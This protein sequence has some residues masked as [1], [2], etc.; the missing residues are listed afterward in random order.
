MDSLWDKTTKTLRFRP[1][2]GDL[3]TDVLV[4]G[5]GITGLLCAHFL[6]KA[7]VTCTVIDAGGI[8]QGV[9]HNTTAKI[10]IQHGLIYHKLICKYGTDI[11]RLYFQAQDQAL[12]AYRELSTGIDC[13]LEE[14]DAFV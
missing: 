3:K 1:L 4:I 10:T 6:K 12:A 11:A 5:G 13:D 2:T 14:K 9:T 8:C 7:G